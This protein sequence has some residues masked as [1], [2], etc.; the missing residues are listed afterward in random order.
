MAAVNMPIFHLPFGSSCST[1]IETSGEGSHLPTYCRR[2]C[3]M[4]PLERTGFT[5]VRRVVEGRG[6]AHKRV[7]IG[8]MGSWGPP[9]G[10]VLVSDLKS[11]NS[12]PVSGTQAGQSCITL[13]RRVRR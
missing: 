12:W 11:S 6:G 9:C 2:L 13:Y 4:M 5:E 8:F 10:R 3:Q 7:R 1:T